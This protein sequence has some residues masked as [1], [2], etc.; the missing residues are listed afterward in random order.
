M[1]YKDPEVKKYKQREAA[2]QHRLRNHISINA[3]RRAR[4]DPMKMR[5]Q[6]HG[7]K[8]PHAPGKVC[9]AC[10]TP[11]KDGYDTHMDHDHRTEEFRGW[12]CMRC[13]RSLGYAQDSR[14]RLQLLLNYLDCAELLK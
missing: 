13:N 10:S 1:P 8:P 7:I 3:K 6:R 4:Y 12:L 14:D 2:Q 5:E 9:D 11:F